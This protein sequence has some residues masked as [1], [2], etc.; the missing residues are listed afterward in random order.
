MRLI[1]ALAAIALLGAQASAQDFSELTS[2]A[3]GALVGI[4][5]DQPVEGFEIVVLKDGQP[6]YHQ[7]FGNWTLGQVASADSAT[8]TLSG[9]LV[10]AVAESGDGGFSL[11]SRLADFLP[12]YNKPG[13]SDITVRQAFSHTSGLPG[14]DVSSL[15]LTAP[16][17]TLRQ[18]G[19]LVSQQPLENGPPGSAF[20]YGGL[21]MQAVGAAMEVATGEAYIDLFA[22]R[23]AGPLGMSDT[24]FYIAS[25]TNPRVA[26]GVETTAA[27]MARFT[28]ML[29]NGGV[30]R[31]TGTRVLSEASVAEMVTRQTTDAQP[32]ANSPTDNNRYGIGVWIDQLGMAGPTVDYLAAGA[33]GM[34]SWVDDLH[35]LVFA[36][37]TDE[38]SFRF[39]DTLSS[40]MHR[41]ILEEI[42]LP[43]DFNDDGSVDS[44]D[45]TVWR[46]RV[47]SSANELPNDIDGGVVGAAQY[48]TWAANYGRNAS[49]ESATVPEPPIVKIALAF[50]VTGVLRRR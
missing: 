7:A 45:Y 6:L 50:L 9:A 31:A 4:G 18:A 19:F 2:L 14:D 30:D 35:G 49:N 24:R 3:E 47:G 17:I 5:V 48:E 42:L 10:M 15:I 29:L 32:I 1:A 39:I 21:S 28:D 33:R 16:N 40:Q 37:A 44:A 27:D 38:T 12:E 25:D 13:Y 36:F 11:D 23:I 20:A 46:D 26:G 8:K 43:G 22:E 34:H 41:A